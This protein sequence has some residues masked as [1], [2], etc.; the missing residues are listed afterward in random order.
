MNAKQIEA[1]TAAAFHPSP[2]DKTKLL[3]D[4]DLIGQDA[5]VLAELRG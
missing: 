5:A 2:E 4:K 3:V 1:L